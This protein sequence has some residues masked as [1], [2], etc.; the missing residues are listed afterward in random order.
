MVPIR[1]SCWLG[2]DLDVVQP[3]DRAVVVDHLGEYRRRVATGHGWP[4]TA[5]SV[6]PAGRKTPPDS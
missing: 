2:E 6:C 4:S 1:M 5:A 3:G